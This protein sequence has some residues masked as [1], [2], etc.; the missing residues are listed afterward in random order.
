[1]KH[2]TLLTISDDV[3]ALQSLI[4]DV[5]GDLTDPRVCAAIEAW[6][7]ELRSDLTA[8]VD[9][10]AALIREMEHRA[11][12]REDEAR[13]I[14]EL[15]RRDSATASW[16]KERLRSAFERLGIP[17]VDTD[18]FSVGLQRNGGLA[19]LAVDLEPEQLPEWAQ[20]R[21]VVVKADSK[22]IRRRL[23]GGEQFPFARIAERG[24]RIVIR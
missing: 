20:V 2:R 6:E 18:R 7:A 13:R 1:M 9:N 19:P 11:G 23:E 17:K 5:D 4:E 21:T 12:A 15:G 3:L 10:Y 8:K 16:L 14:M 22:E 24:N